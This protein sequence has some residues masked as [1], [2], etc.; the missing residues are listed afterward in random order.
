MLGWP[1][2][3]P[4]KLEELSPE[5]VKSDYI[6]DKIGPDNPIKSYEDYSWEIYFWGR[7]GALPIGDQIPIVNDDH[8]INNFTAMNNDFSLLLP[9][10]RSGNLTKDE[11]ISVVATC[12]KIID[13][14]DKFNLQVIQ[15]NSMMM[16]RYQ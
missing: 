4:L 7:I 10:L 1:E 8:I 15:K 3:P 9:S 2:D 12:N 13:D 14:M 5:P 6:T 11:F 16:T